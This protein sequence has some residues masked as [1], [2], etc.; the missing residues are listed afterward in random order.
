VAVGVAVVVKTQTTAVLVADVEAIEALPLVSTASPEFMK[1]FPVTFGNKQ[2]SHM[3]RAVA[4]FLTSRAAKS[5]DDSYFAA[6][7]LAWKV[8]P[9][10]F[11]REDPHGWGRRRQA[12]L[13]VRR[14]G[15]NAASLHDMRVSP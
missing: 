13:A 9:E 4:P 3:I 12:Q 8:D 7:S 15:A 5:S 1:E 10:S 14:G 6:L 11:G 2:S